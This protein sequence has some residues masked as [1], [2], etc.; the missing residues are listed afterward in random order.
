MY[1]VSCTMSVWRKWRNA[2]IR[3]NALAEERTTVC[4]PHRRGAARR[5]ARITH[6]G[7]DQFH[8]FYTTAPSFHKPVSIPIQDNDSAVSLDTLLIQSIPQRKR[9]PAF[10]GTLVWPEHGIIRATKTTFY[11][12]P[13]LQNPLFPQNSTVKG[14]TCALLYCTFL[15]KSE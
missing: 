12:K 5:H 7:T 2:C 13:R 10:Y 4:I 8:L 15:R 3:W 9:F 14:M 6:T 11:I 1:G